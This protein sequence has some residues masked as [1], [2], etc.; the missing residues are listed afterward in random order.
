MKNMLD[1]SQE[2]ILIILTSFSLVLDKFLN[3]SESHFLIVQNEA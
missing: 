2:K 3:F 1:F